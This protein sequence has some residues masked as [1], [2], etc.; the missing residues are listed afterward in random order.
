MSSCLRL[1][2]H[3]NVPWASRHRH[4]LHLQS[5]LYYDKVLRVALRLTFLYYNWPRDV[6]NLNK[7]IWIPMSTK[8][9]AAKNNTKKCFVAVCKIG[10]L[11]TIFTWKIL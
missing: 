4:Q 1:L 6:A 10:P 11:L 7:F 8:H 5:A 3:P 2:F 9:N